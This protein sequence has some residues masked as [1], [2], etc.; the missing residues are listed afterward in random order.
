MKVLM[1]PSWYPTPGAPLLGT[2]YKEQA[3]ALAERGVEMAVAHVSVGGDFRPSHNGIRRQEVNG[4]LAYVYTRPNLT[5][6]WEGGRCWQRTRML[7]ALYRRIEREWGRPDVVNLRSSLHGYEAMALCRRHGLPLFFM[8]HSSY[9]LTEPADSPAVRRLHAVMKAA[10]V[11]ACVSSALQRV[12]EPAGETRVIPDPVDGRAFYPKETP[13]RE[14]F[15]FRAMG[16]LRPIKGYDTLIRA[17]ALLKKRSARP[18]RL[19]IAGAGGM[20]ESLQAQ[21]DEARL[22]GDC[23]L[24]G[25]VPRE[26]AVDFMN[27]CD[28]FVCSSRVETLSC[29]LNEAAACGKPVISTRCGGPLDIVTEETGL[30]VPVDDPGAM[31]DAMQRMTETAA[32]Y[33]PARIRAQTLERFGRDTVCERLIA[34]CRDAAR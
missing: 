20:R 22:G 7:E 1:V 4:V 30:L 13:P 29:V 2:F 5:P 33:D 28:C 24:V 3:E 14:A 34:A 16:Q 32:S 12:M 27:G 15:T 9:V 8:E 11:N 31:A 21:I 26:Q 18:L 23:R 10:R 6:R 17:F 19:E 25:T